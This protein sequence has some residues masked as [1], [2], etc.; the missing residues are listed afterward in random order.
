MVRPASAHSPATRRGR[1]RLM[2]VRTSSVA[3]R[4]GGHGDLGSREAR[5]RTRNLEHLPGTLPSLVPGWQEEQVGRVHGKSEDDGR[6]GGPAGARA[7]RGAHAITLHAN[8][9]SPRTSATLQ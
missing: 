7:C 2:R 4:I 8:P 9:P 3:S 5:V 1:L 6:D